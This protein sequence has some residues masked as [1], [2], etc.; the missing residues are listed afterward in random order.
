[1]DIN[2]FIQRLQTFFKF[3]MSRFFTF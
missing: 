1:M 3:L 2:V